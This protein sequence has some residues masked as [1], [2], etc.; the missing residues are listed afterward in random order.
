MEIAREREDGEKQTNAYFELGHAHRKN[1]KIQKAIE[2]YKEALDI[3]IKREDKET[4]QTH[5]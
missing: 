1:N 4:K 3:S 5:T 2:Y